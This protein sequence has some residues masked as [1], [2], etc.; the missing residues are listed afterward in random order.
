MNQET[1]PR[2][3]GDFTII[4]PEC[5]ADAEETVICYKGVNY[6]SEAQG[7]ENASLT[8]VTI[9]SPGCGF[10]CPEYITDEG[11]LRGRCLDEGGR[12]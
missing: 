7:D 6:Y 8:P 9:H 10:D 5:F 12:E 2:K 4:G 1:G 3:S 11:Q